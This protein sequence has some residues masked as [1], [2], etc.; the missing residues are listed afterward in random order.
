MWKSKFYGA[1]VLNRRVL[2]HAIDGVV[3]PAAARNEDGGV[4]YGI[5]RRLLESN[6][7]AGDLQYPGEYGS[8]DIHPLEVVFA[9][10]GRGVSEKTLGA[11]DD[12]L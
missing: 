2:L 7:H 11:Y 10:T 1:F 3:T 9:K 12:W 6:A 5:C 4:L 8:T